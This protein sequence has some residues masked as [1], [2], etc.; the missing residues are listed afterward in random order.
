LRF[1]TGNFAGW[2]LSGNTGFLSVQPSGTDG[3]PSHSGNFFAEAGAVGSLG[4]LSQ[5]FADTVGAPYSVSLYFSSD[6][7]TPNE[8]D[9]EWDGTT[10]FEKTNI[11]ATRP[12]Y[13]QLSFTVT[14]TGADTLAISERNDPGFF[15]I[16]DVSVSRAVVPEPATLTILGAALAALGLARRRHGNM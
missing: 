2:T 8:F 9:V 6:G 4:L 16:D 11:A 5:T 1:E 15:A 13:T 7:L 3:Y 10:L 14:G 12:N